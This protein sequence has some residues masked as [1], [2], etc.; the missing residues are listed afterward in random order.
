MP[1]WFQGVT[2]IKPA[3]NRVMRWVNTYYQPTLRQ[4]LSPGACC[5]WSSPLSPSLAEAVPESPHRRRG[6][7]MCCAPCG[8]GGEMHHSNLVLYLPQVWQ[9]WREHPRLRL[10]E[11]HLVEYQGRAALVTSF[12]SMT[13]VQLDVV[14]A[15][16]TYE[17][18]DIQP[19]TDIYQIRQRLPG[20]TV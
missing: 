11:E 4:P 3:F 1:S 20:A 16:E 5:G 13:A 17:V 2:G 14:L 15:Q 8:Q 9:F 19:S 7:L 18:L 10:L 6:M 12:R